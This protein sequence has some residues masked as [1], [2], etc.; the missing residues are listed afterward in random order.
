MQ[1][2]SHPLSKSLIGFEELFS[3]F[4][5]MSSYIISTK[6]YD[7][8]Y[9]IYNVIKTNNNE[10]RIEIAVA[11]FVKD[12]LEI[13]VKDNLMTLHASKDYDLA[14]GLPKDEDK[15]N[16]LHKGIAGRSFKKQFKLSDYMEVKNAKLEEGMLVIL[17]NQN[18]PEKE[19]P[20]QIKIN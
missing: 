1:F 6:Y 11:G 12:E 18:I 2:L 16:Y 14:T 3:E 15:Q 5:R 7:D 19:K 8:K 20:K 9:P 4:D 10:Y 13:E 17:L